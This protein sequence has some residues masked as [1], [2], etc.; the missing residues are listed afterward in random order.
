M[1]KFPI[2]GE[3][4]IDEVVDVPLHVREREADGEGP[5]GGDGPPAAPQHHQGLAVVD[6]FISAASFQE[7][8]RVLT[9]AANSGRSAAA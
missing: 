5:E 9:E 7:M 3:F 2:A 8:T 4:L 1:A 6:S